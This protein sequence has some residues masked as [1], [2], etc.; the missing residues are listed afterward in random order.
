MAK[1]RVLVAMSGGVDSSVA[2]AML[3]E[4]GYAVEGA[5][6]QIWRDLTDETERITNGCCSLSAVDDA[7]AVCSALGIRYHVFNFKEI[8]ERS[9]VRPFVQEYVRG[10]TPNP[11]ILCNR[12]VKFEAFLNRALALEFDYIATGHY[13]LIRRDN[14]TG[15]YLLCRSVADRKDQTYAL[16]NLTQRQLAHLLLPVGALDKP[17][18]RGYAKAHGL[19]VF[20]KPDSQEICFVR[21]NDYAA[22]IER[23]GYPAVPGDFVDTAGRVIGRHRG[24]YHYTIGQR[25][26]LGMT[27]GK[28]MFVTAIDPTTNRV[29]LGENQE[30]FQQTLYA[31]DLNWIAFETLPPQGVRCMAK[32][33]YNGPA[34]AA[35]VYPDGSDSVRVVFE[36]PARAVTPGQSAVFYDGDVVLGGGIIK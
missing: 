8:F 24:I 26:H 22:F 19:P 14:D 11:C 13:G 9:V 17:Q 32:I 29:T 18:V 20:D 12:I 21:D 4:Q 23:E 35:T 6:M 5:T 2:A 16:Y 34:Q 36:Q 3:L 30:T 25:K 1:K 27:F 10:R 7:R 15:R 31:D 33:R 28:P